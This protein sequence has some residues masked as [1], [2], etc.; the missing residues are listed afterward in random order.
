VQSGCCNAHGTRAHRCVGLRVRL[1]LSWTAFN[2]LAC[3]APSFVLGCCCSTS[4]CS[5][6]AMLPALCNA[7]CMYYRL[8]GNDKAVPD[9]ARAACCKDG[10]DQ[11]RCAVMLHAMRL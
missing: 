10:C 6:S 9:A 5:S 4:C 1:T 3:S 7:M 2:A 8:Y 11:V